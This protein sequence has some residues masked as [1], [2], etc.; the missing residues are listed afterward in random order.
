M[1]K[2]FWITVFWLIVFFGFLWYLKWFNHDLGLRFVNFI[3][4]QET[5]VEIPECPVVEQSVNTWTNIVVE[6]SNI[7]TNLDEIK[8]QLR[9]INEKLDIQNSNSPD[10][11]SV[12]LRTTKKTNIWIFPL[13][14]SEYKKYVMPASDDILRDALNLLFEKSPFALVGTKLDN[15]WNLTVTLERVP[16]TSFGGSAAVEQVRISI[17]KTAMQFSQIK[18]VIIV[19]EEVLQP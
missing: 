3:V 2:F 10:A 15:D 7:E 9:D 1:K 8:K 5:V 18:K 12:S 4:K 16:N 19:P 6:Q 13:D 11:V 17:E 14:W